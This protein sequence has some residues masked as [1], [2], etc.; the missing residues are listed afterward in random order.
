[1]SSPF[2]SSEAESFTVTRACVPLNDAFPYLP[3]GSQA[4][5]P[6]APVLPLPE[7]SAALGPRPSSNA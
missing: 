1:M 7:A 3:V 2:R 5:V 6:I 4:A